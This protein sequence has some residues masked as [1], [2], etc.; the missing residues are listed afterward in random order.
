MG[1]KSTCWIYGRGLS[2]AVVA[3]Q[4]LGRG[5]RVVSIGSGIGGLCADEKCLDTYISKY[6]PH[7]F[8]TDNEKIW[9]YVNKYADW[10]PYMN[11]PVAQYGDK[12]YS[13][14]ISLYT[15]QQIYGVGD[16]KELEIKLADATEAIPDP[17]N[18]KEM[19][20]SK[21]GREIYEKLFEQYTKKQWKRD[22]S[23][24]DKSILERIPIRMYWN[25]NYFN[26][27]YQGLPKD[28]YSTFILNLFGET[29]F[30]DGCCE[31]VDRGAGDKVFIC[32]A[33]D[34]VFSYLFGKI[35]YLKTGFKRVKAEQRAAVINHCDDST[36]FTRTT[37]Y[38]LL[39]PKKRCRIDF[40]ISEEPL[41]TGSESETNVDWVEECYPARDVEIFDKYKK[42]CEEKGYILCGRLAQNK[43]LNMDQAIENAWEICNLYL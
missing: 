16:L 21:V 17:K 30:V 28:G 36:P 13:M 34:K 5:Y 38:S 6:G 42:F 18:A 43:Y 3:E 2:A 29:E 26:D 10:I 12:Y 25:N 1:K 8:H 32:D 14:P 23:E 33:P 4:A 35:P 15:L 40:T 7:I 9:K 19:A 24:L 39:W 27:T 11:A 41:G 22:P 20:L 37:N 31:W